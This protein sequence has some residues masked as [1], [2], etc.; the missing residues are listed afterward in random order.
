MFKAFNKL[1]LTYGVYS[2]LAGLLELDL[3]AVIWLS[4]CWGVH[5]PSWKKKM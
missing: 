1:N 4:G 5:T 3:S 2:K